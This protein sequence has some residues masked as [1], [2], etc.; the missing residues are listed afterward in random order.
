M[1]YIPQARV[2]RR[3][4]EIIKLLILG[5]TTS[6]IVDKLCISELTYKTHITNIMVELQITL[7]YQILSYI[8]NFG[9]PERRI[10]KRARHP[11]G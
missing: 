5:L 11:K 8:M 10:I 6:E 4:L 1:N 7:R 9:I 3:Q 2:T